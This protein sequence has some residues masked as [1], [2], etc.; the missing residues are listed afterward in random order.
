MIIIIRLNTKY[1]IRTILDSKKSLKI[2][3]NV[4]SKCIIMFFA[5]KILKINIYLSKCFF[6]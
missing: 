3:S 5:I 2:S 1:L 4:L 6:K